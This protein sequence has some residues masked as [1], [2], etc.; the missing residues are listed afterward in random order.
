MVKAAGNVGGG[1]GSQEWYVEDDN[2]EKWDINKLS[3]SV[4]RTHCHN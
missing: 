1:E 2:M 4:R 3:Y